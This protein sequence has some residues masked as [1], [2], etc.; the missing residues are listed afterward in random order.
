MDDVAI[1]TTVTITAT[2][3]TYALDRGSLVVTQDEQERGYYVQ[4]FSRSRTYS[5]S[6]NGSAVSAACTG[7]NY[8]C[9][10]V[11]SSAGDSYTGEYID[12]LYT[13]R[14]EYTPMVSMD[15]FSG[16]TSAT[17]TEPA[18]LFACIVSD[19]TATTGEEVTIDGIVVG[20]DI[21]TTLTVDYGDAEEADEETVSSLPV[22]Y[23]FDQAGTYTVTISAEN[24]DNED[25]G[26][27]SV[28]VVVTDAPAAP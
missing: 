28:D 20:N 14:G 6:Y 8:P 13:E 11:R 17:V 18:N 27:C 26:T 15:R 9:L 3:T 21:A 2:D 7:S 22:S 5:W 23:T 25:P 10:R 24:A 19:P 1:D 12:V 16:S 4:A